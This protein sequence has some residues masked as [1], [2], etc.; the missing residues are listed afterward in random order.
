MLDIFFYA[1]TSRA[2]NCNLKE[3]HNLILKNMRNLE[4]IAIA[5]GWFIVGWIFMFIKTKYWRNV[6]IKKDVVSKY[7]DFIESETP[8]RVYFPI[9]L[10][11]PMQSFIWYFSTYKENQNRKP[12]MPITLLGYQGI[13]KEGV[14]V[15]S[16]INYAIVNDELAYTVYPGAVRVNISLEKYTTEQFGIGVV[17]GGF[18]IFFWFFGLLCW[19]LMFTTACIVVS[20][21]WVFKGLSKLFAY[22]FYP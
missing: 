5:Y 6:L 8:F 11:W 14:L 18:H 9:C 21:F 10:I 16:N 17:F 22:T 7:T 4:L 13:N 3:I 19:V 12:T 2:I 1:L 15:R 20:I